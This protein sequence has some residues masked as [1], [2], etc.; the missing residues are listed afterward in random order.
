MLQ[1]QETR[2]YLIYCRAVP[3]ILTSRCISAAPPRPRKRPRL[4]AHPDELSTSLASETILWTVLFGAEHYIFVRHAQI[5]HHCTQTFLLSY[6]THYSIINCNFLLFFY[7]LYSLELI[8]VCLLQLCLIIVAV[9][10]P[11]TMDPISQLSFLLL[12]RVIS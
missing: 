7:I 8:L 6:T 11:F 3:E 9:T 5:A 4:E 12:Y 1:Q 10:L 2:S